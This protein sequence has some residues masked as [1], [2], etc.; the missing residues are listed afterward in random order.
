MVKVSGS[1]RIEINGSKIL[2]G[3]VDNSERI[4]KLEERI[5]S[6]ESKLSL[7]IK[8]MTVLLSGEISILIALA[9]IF[10]K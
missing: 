1:A 7:I 5:A 8:F 9:T 3:I 10:L 2:N 6:L 4:A